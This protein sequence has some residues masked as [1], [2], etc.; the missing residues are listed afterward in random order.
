TNL[1]RRDSRRRSGSFSCSNLCPGSRT[2]SSHLS[3][4]AAFNDSVCC[5]VRRQLHHHRRPEDALGMGSAA[6]QSTVPEIDFGAGAENSL[7][8]GLKRPA[9]VNSTDY[10]AAI[11][12]LNI[13]RRWFFDEPARMMV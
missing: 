10:S 6:E 9:L 4:R 7:P 5:S 11:N 1:P 13:A 12:D 3:N 8:V 2:G